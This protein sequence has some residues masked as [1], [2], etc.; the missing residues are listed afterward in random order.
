M[1]RDNNFAGPRIWHHSRGD[2]WQL[3]FFYL[4]NGALNLHDSTLELL[5]EQG[6]AT[7]ESLGVPAAA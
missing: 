6:R 7:K 3:P 4:D 2:S 1:L 5:D